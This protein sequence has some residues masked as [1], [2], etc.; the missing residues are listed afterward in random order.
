M[1]AWELGSYK[2]MKQHITV[3]QLNDLDTRRL[4]K[5]L[6]WFEKKGGL[7]LGEDTTMMDVY[8]V[9]PDL[10]CPYIGQMI[11]FLD[12]NDFIITT[13]VSDWEYEDKEH[14]E[15]CDALWEAVKEAL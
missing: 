12:E 10:C 8:R 9:S 6:K 13:I 7:T 15:L 1:G 14:G 3:E 2:N 4:E 5:W 11:E